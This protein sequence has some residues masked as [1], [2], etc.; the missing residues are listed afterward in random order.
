MAKSGEDYIA[1]REGDTALYWI[2]DD[3][4]KALQTAADGLKP[5]A[6]APSK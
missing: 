4:I 2:D 3:P 5:A 1:K 6:A